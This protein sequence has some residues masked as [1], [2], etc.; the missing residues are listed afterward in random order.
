[1]I[2]VLQ[3]IGSLGYA[4]VEAVVMNYYRNIDITKVQFDFITCSA[5]RE[6]YDEEIINRGGKIYR[7]PS[8]SR[9]PLEY[10]R[11]LKMLLQQESYQ[12]IHIHQNSASMTMDALVAK[13][14]GIPNIIGHSHNTSCNVLYQHYCFK[15]FVNHVVTHR[16][17]CSKEAG[18]WVF[19]N[20]ADILILNNAVDTEKFLF[21]KKIRTEYR[22]KLGIT[23][24][25]VL[26]FVGRLHEQKNVMRLLRIFKELYKHNSD[27]H[28]LIVGDGELRSQMEQY[29]EENQLSKAID[30]L[31]RRDDVSSL[32]MAM[33]VFIL[34]SL[35][36]GM[37]VVMV[38]A[39]A[40]GLSCVKSERVPAP[41][42]LGNM[43]SIDL[44]KSDEYWGEQILNVNPI[45]RESAKEYV[46]AMG[47][48]LKIEAK[49]LE[50]FYLGLCIQK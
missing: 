18:K 34:P 49:K 21:D 14:C 37:P 1:M 31:G 27:F 44:E 30:L 25:Y 22:E 16:M 33:D 36:E 6:R 10:M 23:D 35:Y 32:M 40:T 48:D 45:E 47:Y 11:A 7:L 46:Q 17:A 4:G 43:I 15:P 26:G 20:R 41:N 19:G 12:I 24:K 50:D 28:L 2:R 29:I 39:Q 38:E 8:R 42:I 3:I 9:K 13:L 5:V